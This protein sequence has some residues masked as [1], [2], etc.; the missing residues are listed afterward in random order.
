MLGNTLFLFSASKYS[1][2]TE[3]EKYED[4]IKG[5]KTTKPS[6]QRESKLY[7]QVVIS[8][9]ILAATMVR[10]VNRTILNSFTL[11]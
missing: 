3:S 1:T 11:K 4:N 8:P 5:T 10:N 9:N 7:G 6:L 2:I